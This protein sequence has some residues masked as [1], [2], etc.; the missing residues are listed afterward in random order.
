[1]TG[2]GTSWSIASWTVQRPSPGVRD[3]A[4]DVLEVLAVRAERPAGQLEQPRPDD[5]ALHPQ[6]GDARE[7]ELVVAGVHDLEAFG[8]GL[9]QAVLDAVVDHLH[10][11]AGA[12]SADVQ[13][14]AGRGERR[15]DG[16]ERR[17]PHS[18]SPPTI[19]Q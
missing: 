15:E 17:R 6:L 19:R 5:R 3:E 1:M 8:V 11:V 10:V 4:L 18:A 7:V 14:A 16:H 9:H 2:A 13:V 12:R